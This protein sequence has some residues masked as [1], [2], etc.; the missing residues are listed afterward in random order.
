MS[1]AEPVLGAAAAPLLHVMSWNIRRR[2]APPSLRRADRWARRAPRLQALLQ[3][4][5]PTLLGAQEALADQAGFLQEA[6][7]PA[8][9]FLGRGR[10]ISGGE[11]NPIIYDAARLEALDWH[12]SA[13][14][15]TP[16]KAGSRSWGALFPR[17]LVAARFRD[18]STG[19]TF[20]VINTHLDHLSAR[21]RVK[22]AQMVSA[23]VATSADPVVVTGD[24]NATGT[25]EPMRLLLAENQLAETW[26]AAEHHRTPQ[27]G[28]LG[29]YRPP[30][31]DRDRIDWILA[32]PSVQVDSVA[33]NHRRWAGGW[34]SDHLP[35]QA[36][37][38]MPGTRN[39]RPRRPDGR[40]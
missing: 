25:S 23:L 12:Q 40:R 39:F 35:V 9:R 16:W 22:S 5:R 38:H 28:T 1:P 20:L 34:G 37:L 19:A 36:L 14:S 33:I 8:Y 13:L 18:R 3:A 31:R 21:S 24:F 32:T 6:L 30:R 27:W 7:G 29:H 4:E 26:A 2:S 11:G 10:G 17:I 15:T